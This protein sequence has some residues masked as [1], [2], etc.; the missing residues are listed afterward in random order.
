MSCDVTVWPTFA[1]EASPSDPNLHYVNASDLWPK[2][3]HDS[4]TVAGCH[5]TD[6][7]G[8]LVAEFYTKMIPIWLAGSN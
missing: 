3:L 2:H 1:L 4:P 8:E 6:E 7:G 5:P